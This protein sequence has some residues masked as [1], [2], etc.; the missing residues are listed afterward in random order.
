L[1]DAIASGLT[2]VDTG[3]LASLIGPSVERYSRYSG[4]ARFDAESP[5]SY[6]FIRGGAGY[7]R[8]EYDGPGPVSFAPAGALPEETIE[9]SF[10]GGYTTELSS[11]LGLELRGGVSGGTRTFDPAVEGVPAAHIVENGSSLGVLATGAGQSSRTDFLLSPVMSHTIG[12]SNVRFGINTRVSKHSMLERQTADYF[13]SSAAS[14]VAGSGYVA[15]LDAPEVS[16]STR[17]LGAFVDLESNLGPRLHTSVGVRFDYEWLPDGA[18]LNTDWLQAS[19]LRNDD[20][21]NGLPQL[22]GNVL[23][24]WDADDETRVSVA[25]AL[26]H[27]DVDSR[28]IAQLLS[29]DVDATATAFAG[30]GLNWPGGSV[31]AGQWRRPALTL[32]GPDTR[33]PRSIDADV[34]LTRTLFEGWSVYLGAS[35]RRTDFLVRRRNLNL[36]VVPGAEDPNGRSIF[37]TLQQ[38]GGLVTAT[39]DDAL[40]FDSFG[41]VWALDP[42]GW[43]SYVGASGGLEYSSDVL[44]LFATYTYSETTDNWIGASAVAI[45]GEL[46]PLLPDDDWDDATSDLDV[47]HRITV[48]ASGHFGLATLS[49]AYRFR[50]GLPFTPGYRDGVDANGDGSIRNDVAFLDAAMVGALLSDWPCLEDQVGG[51]AA[52]N[53]CR[54]PAVHSLDVRV[55]LNVGH[56]A[57]REASLVIDGF[58]LI[59]NGDGVVDDALLLVD[60]DA[61]I[62]TSPDGTV[63]TIPFTV[64]PDFG[65][66]LYPTSRGRM[67][68]VGFRIG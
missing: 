65:R 50:S 40:R 47:P 11:D 35:V 61:S 19:G 33:A 18:T 67:I 15:A 4:L 68:R 38:D 10:A 60:P 30:S 39:G 7:A 41:A 6:L 1:S 8:R 58:N 63:V 26:H 20:Y 48:G 29:Q 23:V 36:P 27:G 59:E 64:N 53:S 31:P 56:V 45:D 34:G 3:L 54:G 25:F 66:I 52:R 14:L 28:A 9:Y 62:V 13:F 49:G 46:P 51:F 32:L 37:G 2:G 21:P 22:G 57:G 24:L 5:T 12:G 17:E 44:D 42:D 16:F 43:S 55:R